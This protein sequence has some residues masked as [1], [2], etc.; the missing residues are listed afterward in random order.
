MR[1]SLENAKL[2]HILLYEFLSEQLH[3]RMLYH[4]Y[5]NL[6]LK[7]TINI[8]NLKLRLKGTNTKILCFLNLGPVVTNNLG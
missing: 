3:L 8:K 6:R 5:R 2:V 1:F 4:P 7:C